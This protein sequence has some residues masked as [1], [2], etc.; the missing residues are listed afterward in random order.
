M[1]ATNDKQ[2][3]ISVI[4]A[5]YNRG[6]IIPVTLQHLAAQTLSPSDFEVV[7]VDDGSTDNTEETVRAIQS[8]LPY[9]LVY[10]K[11]PNR[12]ISCTQNRGIRASRAPIVCL[13][14]DDIHLA[15]QALQAHLED[16]RQNP[17]PN[18]AILGRVLQS[19]KLTRSVF[20]KVW[21]PFK[22]SE[23]R[24]QREVS[25]QF[26]FAC[27]I[28][29]QKEFLLKNGLFSEKLVQRGA[30]AHEDVELGYRLA[31][32]GL[33][34]LYN[35]NALG[36]HYHV[37]TLDKAMQTA[38]RKGLTWLE[39]RRLVDVPE[40]TVRYH[41]LQP[42]FLKDYVR[43]F[44]KDNGLVG[45]D[46]KPVLLAISQLG[47]V[48]LFNV[49]TVPFFW[50][51]IMKKAETSPMLACCMHK[52]FYRCVISHHFHKGVAHALKGR[53]EPRPTNIKDRSRCHEIEC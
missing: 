33:R 43:A 6:D 3:A 45:L 40:L 27:N 26:F 39:F 2:F 12:G 53:T 36:Y 25:F 50:L 29:C 18:I 14:A 20:L 13:I 4:I 51:P 42:P 15:P 52:L 8:D 19:P 17:E 30:Y 48:I 49:I 9:E 46:G 47:R 24:N 21:D 10:L 37:V 32:K 31:Q 22:F 34:I 35:K 5:T 1:S 44:R 16:H 23:L 38:Y 28:S 7:V 41:V 11:H